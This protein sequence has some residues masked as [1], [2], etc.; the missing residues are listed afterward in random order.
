MTRQRLLL[1]A[2]LLLSPLAAA[3]RPAAILNDMVDV[4]TDFHDYTNA[5]Y[6]VNT[7]ASF[8]PVTASGVINWRRNQLTPH[9]AFNNMEARLGANAGN[10]FPGNEYATNPALPFSLQFVSPRTVRIRIHTGPQVAPDAPS[11][12]LVG[13][14]PSDNSWKYERINGGHRYA[15]VTGSITIRENPWRIELRDATGKLLTQTQHPADSGKVLDPVLP[16]SFIRRASDYSRSIGAVFTLAAGEK[17]FGCG[18]SFTRLDKRGQK[19]VLWTNDANG[20]ENAHMY[21][22]VPFFLSSRGY[23]MFVHTSAPRSEERRVGKE[24]RSRW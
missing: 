5:Y 2:F 3:D 10:V 17:L 8:D 22:P 18:G 21:K 1:A 4:S 14:P 12:M 23:G 9:L 13:E 16:F 7:L 20:V 19:I 11:L 6:L 24:C 15:S